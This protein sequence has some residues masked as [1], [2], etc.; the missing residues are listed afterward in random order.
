MGE[1]LGQTEE[2]AQVLGAFNENLIKVSPSW[3]SLNTFVP[4][5]LSVTTFLEQ[6]VEKTVF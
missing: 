5:N 4:K 3:Q 2:I 6:K 1:K